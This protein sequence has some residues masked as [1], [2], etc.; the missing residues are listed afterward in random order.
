[1]QLH[2]ICSANSRER[3]RQPCL[4]VIPAIASS[5]RSRVELAADETMHYSALT[6]ALGG[7]LPS[8]ALSFGG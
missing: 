6:Q 2:P 3:Y 8:G 4:G 5:R 7:K 1:M